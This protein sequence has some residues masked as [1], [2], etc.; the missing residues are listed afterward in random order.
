M[1]SECMSNFKFHFMG[2]SIESLAPAIK[3]AMAQNPIVTGW[4]EDEDWLVFHWHNDKDVTPLFLAMSWKPLQG[5][6][7]HWLE[8]K[9]PKEVEPNIDGSCSKGYEILADV[10]NG[11]SYEVFRIRPI[12]AHHHK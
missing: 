5:I 1:M 4:S 11:W 3:L 8:K 2:C 6:I 12:W 7:E 9:K 10:R